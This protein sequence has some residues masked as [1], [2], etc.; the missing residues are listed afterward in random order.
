MNIAAAF[1]NVANSTAADRLRQIPMEFWMKVGLGI[2]II[3]GTVIL[4][5]KVAQVNKIVL[6]VV[7]GL[8]LTIVGFSWIYERNE[9]SW[10]TPAVKFLS[11]FFP[12]KGVV[13]QKGHGV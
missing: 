8:V 5:R 2:L 6:A 11:G 3:F 4:I 13:Q 7:S 10:A 9:P 1:S 12:T